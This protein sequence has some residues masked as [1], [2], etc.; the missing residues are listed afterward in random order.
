MLVCGWWVIERRVC[1]RVVASERAS[2]GGGG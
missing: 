1:G 2:T